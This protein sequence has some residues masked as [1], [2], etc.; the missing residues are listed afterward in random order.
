M[1][2][3]WPGGYRHAIDQ[4]EHEKWNESNYPGTRQICTKCDKPTG[5]CEEDG[6]FDEGHNP[7]CKDCA[8]E[9]GLRDDD[10]QIY[11]S[12]I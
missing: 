12:F 5:Y 1:G 4:S 7:Y 8:T 10:C 6:Y 9:E 11:G 2:N 3:T